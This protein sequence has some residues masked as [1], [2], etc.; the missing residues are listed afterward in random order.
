MSRRR[1]LSL[2]LFAT[3]W[4]TPES[5]G[6]EREVTPII[7]FG[8]PSEGGHI[9]VTNARL[10]RVTGT[11]VNAGGVAARI[12]FELAEWPQLMIGPTEGPA[13]WS[14]VTAL[15]IP[16]DNPTAEPIDLIVRIDDDPHADGE[17]HSLSGRARVRPSEAGVLILPLPTNDALPMGMVAGPPREAPRL[18][19]FVRMIGGARGAV[20]RRHVTA[21]HLILPRHSP[22]RSLIFGDPGIIRGAD[23]GP[24]IYRSI[25]DG[26]GQYSRARW[27]GKIGSTEDLERARLGRSTSCGSGFQQP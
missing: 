8:N 18:D 7:S 22:G 26:F 17:H 5:W 27:D 1:P 23:P 3:L 20:D 25:V 21:T 19:A 11:R 4:M 10:S 12:D 9:S 14:G 24:E 16:V 15:A 2:F 13:D 6:A